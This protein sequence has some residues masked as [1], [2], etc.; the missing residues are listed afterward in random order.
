MTLLMNK[1]TNIAMDD[2]WVHLMAK[3]LPSLVNNLWWDIFMD[4]WLL[5]EKSLG[6]WQELQHHKSIM[7]QESYKEWQ[8]ILG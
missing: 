8:I 7:P 3:T 1:W 5:D 2:G 4:N 6:K